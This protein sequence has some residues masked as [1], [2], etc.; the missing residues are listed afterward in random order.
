MKKTLKYLTVFICI[1]VLVSCFGFVSVSASESEIEPR[2]VLMGISV[3]K[4]D[5]TLIVNQTTTITATTYNPAGQDYSWASSDESVAYVDQNGVITAVGVGSATISASIDMPINLNYTSIAYCTVTVFPPEG[6]FYLGDLS[7]NISISVYNDVSNA[8]VVISDFSSVDTRQLWEIDYIS[9][10][11]YTIQSVYSG[12]YLS[13]EN[14]SASYGAN[15]I[16]TNT[17]SGTGSKWTFKLDSNGFFNLQPLS[18]NGTE[19]F[20]ALPYGN[21]DSGESL[22]LADF[23]DNCIHW[24]LSKIIQG[25][26][27]SLA[28]WNA[29]S[30]IP[31]AV[32]TVANYWTENGYSGFNCTDSN[33]EQRA[34]NLHYYLNHYEDEDYSEDGDIDPN[35][36][37]AEYEYAKSHG[38]ALGCTL[39]YNI[40]IA[41]EYFD[42]LSNGCYYSMQ[43]NNLWAGDFSYQTIVNEINAGR[44]V[45]LGEIIFDDE[46]DPASGHM[47][48]CV[49]YDVIGGRTFIYVVD[50]WGPRYKRVEF[51]TPSP[52]DFISII[53]VVVEE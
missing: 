45:L 42:Y 38:I 28:S 47:N 53:N 9:G 35:V 22:I 48:V 21:F 40:P 31:C 25:V 17:A 15:I 16:Q 11:Y 32:T 50:A 46:G 49:G 13:V 34:T 6:T 26:N 33:I 23:E 36:N 43:A 29:H 10:G 30:C 4:S 3:S 27:T 7:D 37:D 8:P 44:P 24:C 5:V 20:L 19:L 52:H 12:K 2:V 39:N 18:A 41:F 1:A 51:T 14:N